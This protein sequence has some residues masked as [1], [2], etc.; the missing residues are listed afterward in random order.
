[1]GVYYVVFRK[2]VALPRLEVLRE[3]ARSQAEKS[4]LSQSES[5]CRGDDIVFGFKGDKA[6][7]AATAFEANCLLRVGS[8][9]HRL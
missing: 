9:V 6:R 1:M 4:G 5:F 8:F 7:E 2:E 3:M